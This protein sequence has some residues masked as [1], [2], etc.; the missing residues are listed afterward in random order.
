MDEVTMVVE[1]YHFRYSLEDMVVTVV[2][3]VMMDIKEAQFIV[4]IMSLRTGTGIEFM[5][6]ATVTDRAIAITELKKYQFVN[7]AMHT[8]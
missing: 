5:G 7:F 3:E 1:F 4:M 2:T 6:V 8:K